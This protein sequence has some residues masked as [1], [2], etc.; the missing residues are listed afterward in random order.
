MKRIA[1][2]ILAMLASCAA[3]AQANQ[4]ASLASVE[5]LLD[6]THAGQTHQATVQEMTQI[7][8]Q[9]T[10]QTLHRVPPAQQEK[11]RQTMSRLDTIVREEMNWEK[12]KPQYIRIYAETFTQKEVDDLMA[13]YQTPSGQSFIKKQPEVTR[14][15][16]ALS[17]EKMEIMMK[18]LSQVMQEIMANK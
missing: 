8:E 2:F 5:K 14:K 15:T 16:S 12:I 4:P 1:C 11:F 7:I 13:F 9:S 10:R 3:F 17:Q 6:I 18:R